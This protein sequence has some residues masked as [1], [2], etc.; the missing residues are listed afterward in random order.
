[1][2]WPVAVL[3]SIQFTGE[4]ADT[5]WK[6]REGGCRHSTSLS[7]D[8]VGA[9]VTIAQQGKDRKD[10]RRKQ[11]EHVSAANPVR[12]SGFQVGGECPDSNFPF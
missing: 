6:D 7:G 12:P 10:S 1:M 8:S 3:S 4:T 11:V 5:A 2:N 9:R